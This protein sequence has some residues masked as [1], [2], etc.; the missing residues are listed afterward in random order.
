MV[1]ALCPQ[2]K[3]PARPSSFQLCKLQGQTRTRPTSGGLFTDL[4]FCVC[5]IAHADGG[6]RATPVCVF[7]KLRGP[8][9]GPALRW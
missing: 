3:Q 2:V 6:T 7:L 8:D 1:F 9:P 4:L 5:G